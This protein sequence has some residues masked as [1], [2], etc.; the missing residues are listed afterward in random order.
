MCVFWNAIFNSLH[1]CTVESIWNTLFLVVSLDKLRIR[2]IRISYLKLIW[3]NVSSQLA[4]NGIH[5]RSGLQKHSNLER[6]PFSFPTQLF[7]FCWKL[8][9]IWDTISRDCSEMLGFVGKVADLPWKDQKVTL[10][11]EPV[12]YVKRNSSW[13]S[14]Q[15]VPNE[16]SARLK[17]CLRSHF[18][19]LAMHTIVLEIFGNLS[20]RVAYCDHDRIIWD[21]QSSRHTSKLAFESPIM[22]IWWH[23]N[24]QAHDKWEMY[25]L[26]TKIMLIRYV[27]CLYSC[28]Y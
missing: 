26:N 6:F 7:G 16:V 14:R 11:F 25:N 17:F 3:P 18:N 4:S 24:E 22:W 1:F 10:C 19:Q 9:Q 5:E 2:T 12:L 28:Y 21:I 15:A 13:P 20:S 8:S 27:W 23:I